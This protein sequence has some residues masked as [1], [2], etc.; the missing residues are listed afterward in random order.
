MVF[1]VLLFK[2]EADPWSVWRGRGGLTHLFCQIIIKSALTWLEY[3]N[4]NLWD[5]ESPTSAAKS[6]L[7]IECIRVSDSY[8]KTLMQLFHRK[9]ECAQLIINSAVLFTIPESRSGS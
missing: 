5:G 2:T 7:T 1:A 6:G 9:K 8:Y 3:T 4:K